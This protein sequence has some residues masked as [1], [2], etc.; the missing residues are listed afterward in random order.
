MKRLDLRTPA[1]INLFLKVIGRREDGYHDIYSLFQAIDLFDYLSFE[2]S[3]EKGISLAVEGDCN[4]SVDDGNLVVK[5]ARLMF[6][7]L[8]LPGGLEVRLKKRI[9]IAAGLAGGSSDA[10]ATVYAIDRLYK[11]E[12]SSTRKEN[13][14]LELGSD[15]P[16]FF[17]SGQA[18]VTGRGERIN[19]ISLPVD[20]SI[21]LVVPN[22]AVSS[23]ESYERLSLDLT[24]GITGVKFSGSSDLTELVAQIR[25]I[26]NDFEKG[27]L[28]SYPV[29]GEIKE[30]L[31]SAGAAL[32]RMSGSGPTMFGLFE[33][34]PEGE[35][36]DRISR[37]DWH[38]FRAHPITLP[39]WD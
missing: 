11:L 22:I 31:K 37:G 17:S 33:K 38:V 32:A 12:L 19:D 5:A 20:Y 7:K 13:I 16:F 30:A 26:D 15:V 24:T 1:K 39:A 21:V 2:K 8:K 9:P 34:M 27:H 14:G 6:E 10:A 23:A 35:D 25:G 28:E 36:L 4:L 29:L 3:G 18:E